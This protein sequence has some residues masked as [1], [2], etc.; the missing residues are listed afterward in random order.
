MDLDWQNKVDFALIKQT[1]QDGR[2]LTRWHHTNDLQQIQW[3]TF[4][5]NGAATGQCVRVCQTRT[6]VVDK[7]KSGLSGL[8]TEIT[9]YESMCKYA[10]VAA[11]VLQRKEGCVGMP[12]CREHAASYMS[13]QS[14]GWVTPATCLFIIQ[15]MLSHFLYF[16]WQHETAKQ[17]GFLTLY[18]V[19]Y[20][21]IVMI[22][23]SLRK[24]TSVR[25]FP[26]S[27]LAKITA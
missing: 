6:N 16:Q 20:I 9:H 22:Q 13:G 10:Y 19:I 8:V 4:A 15:L 21:Y 12:F 24:E 14:P 27:L 5:I 2:D 1:N 25:V 11:E 17:P 23:L 3:L 7:R 18:N 26:V